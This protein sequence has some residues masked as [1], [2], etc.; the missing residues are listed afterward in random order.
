MFSSHGERR[1]RARPRHR[2]LGRSRRVH[3]TGTP[4]A[5]PN[6][7]GHARADRSTPL[8]ILPRTRRGARL[9]LFC[10][11][12]AGYRVCRA[13][14]WLLHVPWLP[15]SSM[16]WSRTHRLQTSTTVDQASHT[17]C[18]KKVEVIKTQEI[19]MFRTERESCRQSSPETVSHRSHGKASKHLPRAPAQGADPQLVQTLP[20]SA[21][22]VSPH[23]PPCIRLIQGRS[24]R[25]G[26][27]A[28][29]VQSSQRA[30][31][32]P[33]QAGHRVAGPQE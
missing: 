33:L 5:L 32:H 26:R 25:G 21:T 10:R 29:P 22:S 4:Q 27:E 18:Q 13:L 1:P 12:L 3:S 9:W 15:S 6:R 14:A 30:P 16:I 23:S 20:I 2:V 17:P 11:G 31:A 8:L 24:S 7:N 19:E 28:E